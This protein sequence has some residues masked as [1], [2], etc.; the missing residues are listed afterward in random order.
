M[1]TYPNMYEI[2]KPCQCGSAEIDVMEFTP[3]NIPVRAML[4]GIPAGKYARLR[5][6]GKVVMSETPMEHRTNSSFV[7]HAHGDVL[8]GGLGLGMILLAVQD[9]EDVRSITVI[10]K[11]PDVIA[12]VRHQLP[13]NDKVTVIEGD[14]YTWKPDRKYDC[15]YMDIW[16]YINSDVYEEMK[17]LKRKY[18]HF[19]KSKEES[20][21]RF[22][23]CWAEDYARTNHPLL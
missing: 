22:N 8:V 19:L 2:L 16:S 12:A 14:V 11:N 17:T 21:D 7:W 20:P 10:E 13:L 18:G 9:K 15:I 6:N 1:A 23:W 4:Q 3:G 5:V